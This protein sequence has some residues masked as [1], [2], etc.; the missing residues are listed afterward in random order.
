M[1][2]SSTAASEMQTSSATDPPTGAPPIVDPSPTAPPIQV[3]AQTLEEVL[4]AHPA[5]A[6]DPRVL[7][8]EPNRYEDAT[9]G[10]DAQIS[11]TAYVEMTKPDGTTFLS[12]LANVPYYEGKGYTTGAEQTIPDFVAYLAEQAGGPHVEERQQSPDD[13]IQRMTGVP[14]TAEELEAEREALE[15]ERKQKL[16]VA[17]PEPSNEGQPLAGGQYPSTALTEK[18]TSTETTPGELATAET[19]PDTTE[20]A[21]ETP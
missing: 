18:P 17:Q 7:A 10:P 1:T 6:S 9:S 16:L 13:A 20:P 5:P 11:Q 12:P 15:E 14:K 4:A 2:Q 21:P 3:N 19:S 8:L